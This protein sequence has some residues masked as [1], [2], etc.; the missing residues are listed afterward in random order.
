MVI[1]MFIEDILEYSKKDFKQQAQAD[2]T[3]KMFSALENDLFSDQLKG[4]TFDE[5]GQLLL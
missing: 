2:Q 3:D 4:N 1:T 5:A